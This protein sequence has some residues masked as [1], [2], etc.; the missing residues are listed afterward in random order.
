MVFGWE[1][2]PFDDIEGVHHAGIQNIRGRK[3]PAVN[4]FY[5]AARGDTPQYGTPPPDPNWVLLLPDRDTERTSPDNTFTDVIFA[6][7]VYGLEGEQHVVYGYGSAE[8]PEDDLSWGE[9]ENPG[10]QCAIC[11]DLNDPNLATSGG[12]MPQF[13][14]ND[15]RGYS[16]NQIYGGGL[17]RAG[18]G[19]L[20]SRLF[21]FSSDT[22]IQTENNRWHDGLGTVIRWN[23][24]T[25]RWGAG[26]ATSG[27]TDAGKYICLPAQMA[28][29]GK[30][31]VVAKNYEAVPTTIH[32]G[33][34]TNNLC[35]NNDSLPETIGSPSF[36]L[37]QPPIL[38]AVL[39]DDEIVNNISWAQLS[40]KF[41][42]EVIEDWRAV[43]Y[44]RRE[45]YD[46][47]LVEIITDGSHNGSMWYWDGRR[48]LWNDATVDVITS[49]GADNIYAF[50]NGDVVLASAVA[51]GYFNADGSARWLWRSPGLANGH[52]AVSDPVLSGNDDFIQVKNVALGGVPPDSETVRISSDD[53]EAANTAGL[54]ERQWV[55]KT[56][57]GANCGIS[58][59]RAA[60]DGSPVCVVHRE[61]E[62][63]V[64]SVGTHNSDDTV[65]VA[66]LVFSRD[67]APYT[68]NTYA[69]EETLSRSWDHSNVK[70]DHRSMIKTNF[71]FSPMM[72]CVPT[73]D[74][75]CGIPAFIGY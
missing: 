9:G 33:V 70:G 56:D 66:D 51:V 61:F 6:R 58:L 19:A 12:V 52:G 37:N 13:T 49:T 8:I 42:P 60:F 10:L 29:G 32:T 54:I 25:G 26:F 74:C 67:T 24:R 68:T 11:A 63:G 71:S 2:E 14:R 4:A 73:C 59:S 44:T 16:L 31:W 45:G 48:Q 28:E 53:M 18:G 40:T 5:M 22:V 17:D 7:V 35:N 41:A 39:T 50:D 30:A 65:G 15:E 55:L 57:S 38:P 1:G 23:H 3:V 36:V 46:Y 47:L 64:N 62:H 72:D 43:A 20:N 27:T 69:T 75:G 21:G 34:W